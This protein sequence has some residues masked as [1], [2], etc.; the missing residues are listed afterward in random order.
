[1]VIGIADKKEHSAAISKTGT[2]TETFV[3]GEIA[4]KEIDVGA[5][6]GEQLLLQ[7]LAGLLARG[8][9][10]I[11]LDMDEGTD[12]LFCSEHLTFQDDNPSV[13]QGGEST[14]P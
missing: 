12:V 13:V 2:Q 5:E 14:Y 1:M 6:L 4:T 11:E 9:D 8:V 7:D 3:V 10:E